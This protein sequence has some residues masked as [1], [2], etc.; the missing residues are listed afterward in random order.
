MLLEQLI[1]PL[2]AD[3][4]DFKKNLD[5]A[6]SQADNFSRNL[7]DKLQGV[8]NVAKGILAG[9]FAAVGGALVGAASGT[10]SWVEKLDGLSDAL[11][12]T[13]TEGAGMAY[14]MQVVG[15]DVEQLTSS[16]G[17]LTRGLLDAE[18]NLGPTG[19]ALQN[20][21]IS[22]FD[23]NGNL[24]GSVA[25]FQEVADKLGTMPDGLEKSSLLMDIFGKSGVEMGDALGAAANGGLQAYIEK[26]SAAGLAL[27]D[28]Q[29]Q[30]VIDFKKRT[31]ELKLTLE[32]LA[33]SIGSQ[34]LPAITPFIDKMLQWVQSPEGQEFIS[35]FVKSFTEDLLPALTNLAEQG[36]PVLADLATGVGSLIQ[37]FLGLPAPV[38]VGSLAFLGVLA[39][40]PNLIGLFSGIMSVLPVVGT[41]F[42]A[43]TGPIGLVVTAVVGLIA[44]W[45]IFKDDIQRIVQE[46]WRHVTDWFD[47]VKGDAVRIVTEAVQEVTKWWTSLKEN[48]SEKVTQIWSSVTEK[49]GAVRDWLRDTFVKAWDGIRE[50][51]KSVWEW[52]DR[53]IGKFR[54]IKIPSWLTPG[55]PTPFEMGLRGIS[56]AMRTAANQVLPKY[57]AE[58]RLAGIPNPTGKNYNSGSV[59]VARLLSNIQGKKEIDINEL[60]RV[61]R[62]AV[63]M[64]VG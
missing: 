7:Q 36:L 13:S 25:L 61:V 58:L 11:G 29:V 5:D 10:T 16:M 55:S 19:T 63:V 62:D 40:L 20:L 47:K 9:G 21:G 43:L 57:T 48:I 37:G 12:T 28:D 6:V 50:A 44:I 32:G 8:S 35:G 59:E 54:D 41:V 26:A 30:K 46:I 49:L 31:E 51:I 53:L 39:I 23:A 22:A 1:V 27:G 4:T 60:A 64:A 52:V 34:L 24:K 15:G 14:M 45:L 33:V 3:I 42:G 17:F 2:L 38:Q 18:G 56:D